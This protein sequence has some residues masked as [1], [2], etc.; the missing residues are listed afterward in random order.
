MLA[1]Q[2]E[3]AANAGPDQQAG[4]DNT[5]GHARTAAD[6]RGD[7]LG[8]SDQHQ[9]PER[10]FPVERHANRV[11]AHTEH[12]WH[13]QCQQSGQQTGEGEA[14]DDVPVSQA[15][16]AAADVNEGH[17]RHAASDAQQDDVRN[18]PKRIQLQGRDAQRR[19]ADREGAANRRGG[20]RSQDYRYKTN[21]RVFGDDDFHGEYNAGQRCVEGGGDAAGRAA[22]DQHAQAVVGQSQALPQQAVDR[23][24]FAAAGLSGGKRESATEKL[25]QCVTHRQYAVVGVHAAEHVNDAGLPVLAS[26]HLETDPKQQCADGGQQEVHGRGE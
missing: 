19:A 23:G 1:C 26:Q 7:Q 24:A 18:F 12:L 5:D 14:K 8:Q 10:Q 9:H 16:H 3:A 22:G 2:A 21:H 20:H 17:Q 11:I 15:G 25:Y 13:Q 6:R 4:A